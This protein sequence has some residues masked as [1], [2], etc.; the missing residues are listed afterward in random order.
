MHFDLNEEQRQ[1]E[2]SLNSYF[3]KRLPVSSLVSTL[4]GATFNTE[5][6]SELAELGIVGVLASE[7]AGGL[8]MDLLTLAVI[9]ERLGYYAAP[10]PIIE[11]ALCAWLLSGIDN[12]LASEITSGRKIAGLSLEICGAN[13]TRVASKVI[14]PGAC[15]ILV[16]LIDDCTLALTDPQDAGFDSV[17]HLSIDISRPLGDISVASERERTITIDKK[18]SEKLISAGKILYAMDAYGAG[19]RSAEL[20]IEYSKERKQFDQLIGSF[21]GLKYQLVE[22]MREQLPSRFLGW[23]A[24]HKWDLGSADADRMACLSK[25]HL[26][27][28]AV[29]SGRT[30]VE[31]HGGI[32]YTW[33]YPLHVF[34]KR[35]MFDRA[36]LGLPTQ[37]RRKIAADEGW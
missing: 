31:C 18:K 4:E 2:E 24:A 28:I 16:R 6:Y 10:V 12:D 1:I 32:G 14:W 35:A 15:N 17:D 19:L 29:R 36:Y 9:S 30:S 33:E 7:T 37:Q 13:A 11:N 5:Q 3:T 34:L 27:D 22:M 26:T 23:I 20:A 8:D 25:S 21:Q